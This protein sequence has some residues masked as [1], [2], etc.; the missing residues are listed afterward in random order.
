MAHL[1]LALIKSS[2]WDAAVFV[3]HASAW[4]QTQGSLHHGRQQQ[5][6]AVSRS[7]QRKHGETSAS[8]IVH[9]ALRASSPSSLPV[10]PPECPSASLCSDRRVQAGGMV[11]ERLLRSVKPPSRRSTHPESADSTLMTFW[12]PSSAWRPL[13]PAARPCTLSSGTSACDWWRPCER[14][15]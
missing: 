12:P 8:F 15:Q 14:L 7:K 2:P 5:S 1:D 10:K 9:P 4:T 11:T 13:P 6:E 3:S